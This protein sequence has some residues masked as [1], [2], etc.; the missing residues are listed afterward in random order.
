M[1]SADD[2]MPWDC[3]ELAFDAEKISADGRRIKFALNDEQREVF[4]KSLDVRDLKVRQTEFLLRPVSGKRFALTGRLSFTVGQDCIVSLDPL[5]FD[6][7]ADINVQFWPED[8][9]ARYYASQS[10]A[11]VDPLDDDEPEQIEAGMV[12]VGR[13]LYEFIATSINPYPRKG[14]VEFN[15]Q[16]KKHSQTD[17][18]QLSEKPF[19]VLK[20]LQKGEKEGEE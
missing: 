19:A 5:S 20:I 18:D 15:W 4:I 6:H 9:V 12:N 10:D 3:L 17:D 2:I 1:V 11:E 14:D 8:A 7:T 13:Y 16:D